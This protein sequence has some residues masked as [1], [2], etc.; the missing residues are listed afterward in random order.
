MCLVFCNMSFITESKGQEKLGNAGSGEIHIIPRPAYLEKGN[1]Y[2]KFN[3]NTQIAVGGNDAQVVR[4]AEY[5]RDIFQTASRISLP[6]KDGESVSPP[7]NTI[8]FKISNAVEHEE[9]YQL[10]VSEEKVL[11]EAR[12]PEGLF[13][14]I[15]TL[16]QMLP[17]EV[18][19]V[20][21]PSGVRW[22]MPAARISDWPRFAWRGMHMDVSRHFFP[23]A[24]IK[25]YIRHL[26]RYKFNKF[27]LHLT[28]GAG[29]RIETEQYPNLIA[30]GSWRVD[31]RH[32]SW[33]W[34]ATEIGKP[35]DGRPAYGGYYS[36]A[37]IREVIEYAKEHFIEVI[38]EI[39]MPGHSYAALVAYPELAC[40]NNNIVVD[41]LKGKDVF[42]AA[43]EQTYTFLE[44]VIDQVAVLFPFEY[45]HLGGDEV[46]KQ[47]WKNC[48]RC[49]QLIKKEGL[50]DEKELQ[51]YFI[52]KMAAYINSKGKRAIGWDE[53]M[54]GGLAENTVVMSWRGMEGGIHAA[55]MGHDVIMAPNSY[56][57]FDLYQGDP[58]L[59]P[60]AYSRLLLSQVY[61]FDPAPQEV[62]ADKRHHVLGGHGCLWTEHIQTGPQAEYMLFPRLL[63]LSETI[64]TPK[65]RL[66]WEHFLGRM[67]HHLARLEA[68]GINYAKSAYQA[69]INIVRDTTADG[70]KAVIKNELGRHAIRYTLDGSPPDE[71]SPLYKGPVVLENKTVIKAATFR[72]GKRFGQVSSV[73]YYLNKA[74][75]KKVRY[76]N[77]YSPQY[78]AGGDSGLANGLLGTKDFLDGRWQGFQ[79]KNLE[80]VIDLGK[81][82][83]ISSIRTHFLHNPASWIYLPRR[84]EF[85]VSEDG[86][87]F[88]TVASFGA[89]NQDANGIKAYEKQFPSQK[90][91]FVKIVGENIGRRPGRPEEKAWVFI[92]EVIVE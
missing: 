22:R 5:F 12:S 25:K 30:T 66:S 17:Q 35:R 60:D 36:K 45:I 27:H 63:A 11:L 4:V 80:I 89:A 39:E 83:A 87:H 81:P 64:W 86:A 37:D 92:D 54:E 42:C 53:V 47:A 14:G 90:A 41:G 33:N 34:E 79:E 13:Y 75:G 65:E 49:Q 15:Q 77:T 44:N 19:A 67:E 51:S 3:K 61:R 32:Q 26:A 40:E 76:I 18:E 73:E 55:N 16:R 82:Q 57:Y 56:A 46:D 88:T 29:W 9:G 24:F 52:K 58:E 31:K 74:T 20:T 1:G 71:R 38:P 59:E 10:E 70:L 50:K 43:N 2:F 62:G 28:D 48:G 72:N 68:A 7:S 8:V 21:P 78:A 23:K 85:A 69:N 91:R 6:I 84:V